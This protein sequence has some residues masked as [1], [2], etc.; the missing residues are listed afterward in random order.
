[1]TRSVVLKR[2]GRY[3]QGHGHSEG[4]SDG[5]VHE[6]APGMMSHHEMHRTGIYAGSG[7]LL[8]KFKKRK[9]E[10]NSGLLYY[11]DYNS[12]LLFCLSQNLNR[13]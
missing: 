11:Y 6:C 8:I 9:K 4:L 2:L 5:R 3:L 1:M 12:Y 10:R 13:G 7:S